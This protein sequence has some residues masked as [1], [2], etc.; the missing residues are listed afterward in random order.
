MIN[1]HR[2][3]INGRAEVGVDKTVVIDFVSL[4]RCI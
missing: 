1:H 2:S 4:S 3:F